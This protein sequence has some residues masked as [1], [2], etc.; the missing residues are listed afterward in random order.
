MRVGEVSVGNRRRS[1]F[2]LVELLVVITIIGMLTALLLPAVQN[3]REAGRRATCNSNQHELSIAMQNFESAKQYFPGYINTVGNN[4][5]QP[6]SWVVA[7]FPY[8]DRRDL[9]DIWASGETG[10]GGT[11]FPI[12]GLISPP[13]A[14]TVNSNTGMRTGSPQLW[15]NYDGYK[16]LPLLNCPSDPPETK[17]AG[18]TWCSYVCNRG[19]NGTAGRDAPPLAVPG[20]SSPN[21]VVPM[22]SAANGVCMDQVIYM[23]QN[24]TGNYGQVSNRRPPG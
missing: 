8:L 15:A 16:Y 3:A 18:D 5:L 19:L 20:T 4:T 11:F 7:L 24:Q 21:S 2:T 22:D 17:N 14:P 10:A 13:T 12:P 9:Y 6:V 23:G 1:A